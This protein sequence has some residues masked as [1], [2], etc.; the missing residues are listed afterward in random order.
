MHRKSVTKRSGVALFLCA[1]TTLM[2]K[3]KENSVAKTFEI[4]QTVGV[5]LQDLDPV[6]AAFGKSICIRTEKRI[7][8]RSKPI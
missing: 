4:L 8:N 3:H 5:A 7:C 6:I 2:G 1:G